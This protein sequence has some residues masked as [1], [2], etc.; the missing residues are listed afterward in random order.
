MKCSGH[1]LKWVTSTAAFGG[2][3]QPCGSLINSMKF[4]S[5]NTGLV[6]VLY[7]EHTFHYAQPQLKDVYRP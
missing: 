2:G 1:I 4:N 7:T 6:N 3:V 5:D